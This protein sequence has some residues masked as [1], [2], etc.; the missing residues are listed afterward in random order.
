MTPP[1]TI[2]GGFK[3]GWVSGSWP[4]GRL[5]VSAQSLVLSAGPFGYFRLAPEQIVRLEAC[6]SIPLVGRGIRIVH[7]HPDYPAQLV[8]WCFQNPARLIERILQ[9]G[10]RPTA[11]AAALPVRDG[12][13]W[14]WSFVLSVGAAWLALFL[15]DRGLRSIDPS[16]RGLFVLV[17]FALLFLVAFS[18]P[19]SPRLQ[20]LALKRGRSVGEIRAFLSLL[21]LLSGIFLLAMILTV[22]LGWPEWRGT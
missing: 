15:L 9:A 14:R 1:F 5:S 2:T 11:T 4:F 7:I 10:F 20:A 18:L 17:A 21:Q 12:M 22:V 16:H 13:P 19:R 8:F 3:A 6:G